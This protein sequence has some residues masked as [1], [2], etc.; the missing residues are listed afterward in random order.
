MKIEGSQL[1]TVVGMIKDQEAI[2]I[3]TFI[4]KVEIIYDY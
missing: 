1:P 2:V 4:Q 3:N